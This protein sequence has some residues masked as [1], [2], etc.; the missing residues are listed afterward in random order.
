M[1]SGSQQMHRGT[2]SNTE[3]HPNSAKEKVFQTAI[4]KKFTCI[5]KSIINLACTLLNSL[6]KKAKQGQ[7]QKFFF[8]FF[9]IFD[10]TPKIRSM[11]AIKRLTFCN[12]KLSHSG[13]SLQHTRKCVQ[14][15]S[16][17]RGPACTRN[18]NAVDRPVHKPA[19]PLTAAPCEDN[20]R[21][22]SPIVHQ[23]GNRAGENIEAV[24]WISTHWSSTVWRQKRRL[25]TECLSPWRHMGA[26]V[27][28]RWKSI[29]LYNCTWNVRV[30]IITEQMH[31]R[32]G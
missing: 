18:T 1:A 7:R 5:L 32:G 19:S 13:I 4:L 10:F 29:R 2:F 26:P 8:Y 22:M 9:L 16:A 27:R 30:L 28:S 25:S 11:R 20:W 21:M 23:I 3:N 31:G 17:P 6:L 12:F 24:A 15:S 14:H